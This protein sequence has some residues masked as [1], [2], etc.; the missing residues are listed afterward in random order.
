M[1]ECSTITGEMK[2]VPKEALTFRI[3]VYAIIK[4]HGKILVQELKNNSKFFFP[5][6]GVELGEKLKDALNREVTEETG[7]EIEIEKLLHT[8]ETFFYYEPENAA[9]QCYSFF[10]QCK[11]L[12]VELLSANAVNDNEVKGSIWADLSSLKK[13]DFK[14]PADEVFHLL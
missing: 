10:Y 4:H 5:G 6:G 7:L 11:P 12:T 8:S 14:D 13:A 2:L 3:S 9:W 1:I